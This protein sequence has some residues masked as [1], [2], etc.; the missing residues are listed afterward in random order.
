ME[1]VHRFFRNF[2]RITVHWI[3]RMPFR[4]ESTIL[5]CKRVTRRHTYDVIAEGVQDILLD[6]CI[7]NK[8]VVIPRI[9]DLT[10]SRLPRNSLAKIEKQYLRFIPNEHKIQST[11]FYYCSTNDEQRQID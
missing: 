2:L 8:F 9:T 10:L 4:R 7:Q 6:N 1:Y 3:E 5:A 11:I